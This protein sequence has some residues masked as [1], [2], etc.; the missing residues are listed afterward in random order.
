MNLCE[1]LSLC[2]YFVRIICTKCKKEKIWKHNISLAMIQ[3]KH[4]SNTK[5]EQ[6]LTIKLKILKLCF[7][8]I[9][10]HFWQSIF[11]YEFSMFEHAQF[12]FLH[13]GLHSLQ[14]LHNKW[15]SPYYICIMWKETIERTSEPMEERWTILLNVIVYSIE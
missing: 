10:Y 4:I 14:V 8:H 12:F 15:R 7:Y 3:W 1:F 11:C 5:Q 9:N 13:Y 6:R 2:K